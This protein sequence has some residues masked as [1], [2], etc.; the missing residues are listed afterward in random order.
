MRTDEL[1]VAVVGAG[2]AGLTLAAAL[3]RAGIRCQVFEQTRHLGEV[4]AGIQIAPNASRIL[5]RLGLAPHLRRTAVRPAAIEMRRWDDN[6]L[7]MRTPLGEEC[8]RLYEAPYYTIHRADLHQ[9]LLELLPEGIVHL[10]LRCVGVEEKPDEVVLHFEGGPTATADVV[11]G[12]DGIHSVVRDALVADEPRFSGQIIYRGLIPAD[13]VSFL[14][15]EP[16]VVLWLGPEQ[17]CVC[18][19]VSSGRLVSFGATTPGS[20]W[21]VESWSAEG[22]VE[23]LVAAYTG[24]NDQITRLLHAP[25]AVRRWALHDRDAVEWWSRGRITIIGDAA[26]PMLPFMAQGANQAIEDA[27]VLAACLRGV[28]SDGVA[29]ALQ[30]Y[31]EIRKPRTA[32]IQRISRENNRT[33]H[34]PDGDRQQQRDQALRGN[35]GLRDQEWLYGYDAESAVIR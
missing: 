8:E 27:A 9:G 19:P 23:D 11:V 30:R 20:D 3:S 13:R 12:A 32:E 7:I 26:H 28:T 2:I 6:Q 35:S 1:H 16:R 22:R 34:L 10:G 31:A 21:R 24:W 18:Y 4:G 29:A 14:P 5:H 33:L 17:H 15:E 25:D